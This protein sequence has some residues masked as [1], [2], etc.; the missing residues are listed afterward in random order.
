M[1]LRVCLNNMSEEQLN[2]NLETISADNLAEEIFAI[3]IEESKKKK[4]GEEFEVPELNGILDEIKQFSENNNKLTLYMKKEKDSY[5]SVYLLNN[6]KDT[7]QI[8]LQD[9]HLQII[10][11]AKDKNGEWKPIEY[12]R[13]STCGNSYFSDKLEPNGIIK[14]SSKS[15][16]GTFKTEI[17]YKL[18][19]NGK[20][21][22]SN[23]LICKIDISQFDLSEKVKN[24][25]NYNDSKRIAGEETAKKII[26]LDA[27]GAKEYM[28]KLNKMR[29]EKTK[30]K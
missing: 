8:S 2:L 28:E 23:S 16:K 21:Y 29:D 24:E 1:L 20:N 6:T 10:Q 11:E 13:Y 15:Y 26:F 3:I 14:T 30:S 5:F 18:L 9:N 25:S 7:L 4:V 27:N 22:Y 17:R 12:W 19:Q